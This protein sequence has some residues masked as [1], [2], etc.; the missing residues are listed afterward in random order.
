MVSIKQRNDPVRIFMR[1]VGLF[2]LG[3]LTL[4]AL[5]AVWDIYHKERESAGLRHEAEVQR[6]DLIGREQKLSE[7]VTELKTDRGVEEVL[8]NQYDLGKKGES[9]IVIVDSQKP[10][11]IEATT[12]VWE[13]I[14]STFRW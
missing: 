10:K 12:T 8:R 3:L 5:V 11:P 9:V 4:A 7:N 13:W 2:A 14:Q 6:D 1:R